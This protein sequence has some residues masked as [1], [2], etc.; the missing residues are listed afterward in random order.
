[1]QLVSYN[2]QYGKGR[3]GAFD[4][5]RVVDQIRD[6]D[7]IALQEVEVNWKRS[8]LVN[9]PEEISRLLPGYYWS[10]HPAFDVG[11]NYGDQNGI[12]HHNR[13]QFGCMILSK[14][15][16]LS[17][18]MHLLPKI[19]SLSHYNSETG[20]LEVLVETDIGPVAFCSLQLSSLSTRER[21]LQIRSLLD[22]HQRRH[23][24]GSVWTGPPMVRNTTDWS[25]GEIP[26]GQ[27]TAAVY[28]GDFNLEPAGPEYEM[29]AGPL[30]PFYGRVVYED[31]LIDC[32]ELIHGRDNAGTTYP[33]NAEC[34]RDMRLDYCF[35]TSNLGQRV[36][37]TFVDLQAIASD[38]Q[39]LFVT[40]DL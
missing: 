20:I 22:F 7:L 18:R 23:Q 13:R 27:S 5:S 39:P 25:N 15:P 12:L 28:L 26:M 34:D 17:S 19:A 2:I 10:Y 36:R 14:R 33:K 21:L 31:S 24:H 38:H 16:I 4:L 32:W 9:Q 40:M 3:D 8:G 30:D 6:M 1:M 11:A 35:V 37:D 29:L